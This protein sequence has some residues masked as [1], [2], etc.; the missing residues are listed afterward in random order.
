MFRSPGDKILDAFGVLEWAFWKKYKFREFWALQDVNFELKK[1]SRLGIIGPNGAGK[2]TLLKVIS[3]N[4][5]PSVGTVEVN[6][7][8][9][10]L[11]ELGT[12]FHPEFTGYENIRASLAYQGFTLNEIKK[13]EQEIA[14]FTEIGQFLSQP[15][16]TY[17]DGM[18]ARLAFATATVIK[19]EIL[20]IDE[21]LGA[22]DAY[23][24]R[25]SSQRMLKMAESG[26]TILLVSHALEQ[27]MRFC[28]ETIWLDR[29]RIVMFGASI[30]V[31]K[32]YEQYVRMLSD[33]RIKARNYKRMSSRYGSDTYDI[34]GDYIFVVFKL[35]GQYQA[36]CDISEIRLLKNGE[37]EE[38]L[39]VGSSQDNNPFHSSFVMIEEG[40]WS[41]PQKKEKVTWRSLNIPKK[42]GMVTGKAAFLFHALFDNTKYDLE[43]D[44]RC[45]NAC[46]LSVEIWKNGY[47][48]IHKEDVLNETQG[49]AKSCIELKNLVSGAAGADSENIPQTHMNLNEKTISVRR[50]PSEGSLAIEQVSTVNGENKEQTVFEVGEPIIVKIL[51]KAHKTGLFPLL[52]AVSIYRLDGILVTHYLEQRP[53]CSVQLEKDQKRIILLDMGSPKFGNGYYVFSVGLFGEAVEESQRYDLIDKSFEFEITGNDPIFAG[54]IFHIP[55]IWNVEIP[56][57]SNE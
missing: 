49:W 48:L 47:T 57:N 26:A 54:T 55:G 46:T 52:P 42:Q 31:V 50:W 56:G 29:G 53:I 15:F 19:P 38:R 23:F 32:A 6:G 20:I 14:D 37:I 44:Y 16:K 10:A 12:G 3:G 33:R 4:I 40:D 7:N 51:I 43:I 24:L 21:V 41:S 28:E 30:E 35:E 9:Q 18:K 13:A 27:I 8:I 34:F 25:K 2:S 17:S 22:G 1:G 45:E 11:M 5:P 39:M 36:C